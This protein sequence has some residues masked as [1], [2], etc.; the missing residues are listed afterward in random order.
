MDTTIAAICTAQGEGGI[1][2]IRISGDD[3]LRIADKVFKN[4]NNKKV[5]DM[6][7]YTAAFGKVCNN[8]EEIDEAV[9]LVYRAPHSYTGENVVEI[10]CHGGIFITKQV[11]RAVLDNGAVPAQ[12]GEF[13]KRAFL[14]GKIDL[15]EAESVIDII[16][17]KSRSAAR[18]ALCVKDG[19]LRRKIDKIKED[20]LSQA[21]HLSAWAD[22][23]E[24]DIAEVSDDELFKTFNNAIKIL[25]GL[26]DTYDS[27]Q[28]V[29]Q[30]IDTVIAGRPNVGKSTLMNLLTGCEKSIVTDIPGTTRDIVED[31]VVLGDVILRLSDTAGLRDTEDRVEQIGVD[32]AKK[33]LEQCG[34]LLAV[35]DNNQILND[36]DYELI[37]NAKNATTIAII[38]KI[39]LEQKLDTDFINDNFENVVYISAKSGECREELI[40]AVEKIA[41]TANLNPSEGILSNER[42]RLAVAN[43]LSSVVEAKSALDAG[44]TYDAVTVSLEDAISNLLELTGE[45]TSDEVIDRVFHNFC[46]G[47]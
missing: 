35:F 23:P 9:V 42:Q 7:G 10:S 27:G 26:L 34:L 46:V 19:A 13:T 44:L 17:A 14:N 20:L 28:A 38:N 1:G 11:L 41:G 6:K 24:E 45:S 47:K 30:G 31:T 4:I 37:K 15:T 40:K 3:S 21:A 2:V 5:A 18:A 25:Q 43:A 29:K 12:A 39:D 8:G 16:S 22:Y 32:R 33:R 36:D